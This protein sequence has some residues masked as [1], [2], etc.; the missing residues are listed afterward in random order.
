MRMLDISHVRDIE[1]AH[2]VAVE[3]KLKS[4]QKKLN[5]CTYISYVL[6]F[7]SNQTVIA[8]DMI[9]KIK[10]RKEN[11]FIYLFILFYF[12]YLFIFIFT[13]I[14]FIYLFFFFFFFFFFVRQNLD[15][16]CITCI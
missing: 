6:L 14:L 11:L 12:I 8:P 5:P 3:G 9:I 7:Y 2:S 4:G 16:L 1:H 13:F 15:Q 10:H